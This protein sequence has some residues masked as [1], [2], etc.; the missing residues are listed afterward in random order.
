MGKE[1]LPPDLQA[2]CDLARPLAQF[3][4]LADFTQD[5]A[6]CWIWPGHKTKGYGVILAGGRFFTHVLS[7]ELHKGKVPVG[8]EVMHLCDTPA[9]YNYHHL[10]VGRHKLNCAL[11]RRDK[12]RPMTELARVCLANNEARFK[13][14][15][16]RRRDGRFSTESPPNPQ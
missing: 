8:L 1:S 12:Q 14:R 2:W 7:Y 4:R 6:V 10:I 15:R 3:Y 5:P 11:I 9:C 13:K 16:P